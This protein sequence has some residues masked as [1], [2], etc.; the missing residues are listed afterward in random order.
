[1]NEVFVD[2]S[3]WANAF[4]KTERYHTKASILVER[5]QQ[6]NQCVVTTNYVLSELIVLLGSRG[7]YRSTVL[8]NIETI[9]L[10]D[11]VEI[12]H[13]DKSLDDKAWQLLAD[14]LDKQWSLVDAVSFIVMQERN[15]TEALTA[16]R[17]FEQAGFVCL[18]K[19]Q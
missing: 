7:Q 6:N 3:G 1:M 2:T 11:W 13:V 15:L 9:R 19:T 4:I 12:V 17:H 14:R 10:A 18:L 8:N 16:D 5:W